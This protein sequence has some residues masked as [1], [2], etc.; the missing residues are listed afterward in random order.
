MLDAR[1]GGQLTALKAESDENVCLQNAALSAIAL[2]LLLP[3]TGPLSRLHQ[4]VQWFGTDYD[5]AIV[6][7][8]C[9]KCV[10]DAALSSAP[11]SAQ[12]KSEH[13]HACMLMC[14]SIFIQS[15]F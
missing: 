11:Y 15:C 7:D 13:L 1:C 8:E 14:T 10:S 12:R 4:I 6:F 3:M 9:H 2:L 5:G